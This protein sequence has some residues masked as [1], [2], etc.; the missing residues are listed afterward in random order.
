[1]TRQTTMSGA[2]KNMNSQR[3]DGGRGAFTLLE[4]IG[5]LAVIA[6]LASFLAPVTVRRIDRAAWIKEITTLSSMGDALTQR[7]LKTGTIPD[8][9]GWVQAVASELSLATANVATNARLRP[10]AFLVD[11]SGWLGA[12][13]PWDQSLAP[14]TTAPTNTRLMI[15]STLAGTNLPAAL[16]SLPSAAI[17]N[18]LWGAPQ[19]TLP[20]NAVWA[21]FKGTGEDILVQRIN[22]DSLF[23][24]LV[25][26]N[27]DSGATPRAAIGTNGQVSI[28]YAPAGTAFL[29]ES[30]LLSLYDTNGNLVS[31]EVIR[32]DVSRLFQN[33]VWRAELDSSTATNDFSTIAAAFFAAPA[34]PASICPWNP[35]PKGVMDTFAAYMFAY[36]AWANESPCFAYHGQ[37]NQKFVPEATVLNGCTNF[38]SQNNGGQLVP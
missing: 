10:R 16:F 6:I 21:D 36:A 7:A 33:G 18:D 3:R 35:G 38:F 25:L 15:V 29:L 26:A 23:H 19:N 22:L 30:T 2:Y 5:V 34:P 37:N 13:V 27:L 17:F 1:M 20:T 12:A 14:L 31:R 11:R 32:S 9:N 24:R 4:L 8:Q 28:N